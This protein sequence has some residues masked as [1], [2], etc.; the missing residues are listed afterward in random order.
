ML[1]MLEHLG[2]ELPLGVV[3]LIAEFLPKSA[4]KVCSGNLLRPE[5]TF[6]FKEHLSI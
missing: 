6:N 1:G 5:V 4:S 3:G 2:V